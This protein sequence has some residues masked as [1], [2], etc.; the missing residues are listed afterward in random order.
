MSCYQH[1]ESFPLPFPKFL[2]RAPHT[3]LCFREEFLLLAGGV[4]ALRTPRVSSLTNPSPP[5]SP[6][7]TDCT[8]NLS[9]LGFG[10]WNSALCLY[11]ISALYYCYICRF[12]NQLGWERGFLTGFLGIKSYPTGGNVIS[13]T[14]DKVVKEDW[15]H[16]SRWNIWESLNCR[17]IR[18]NPSKDKG[19]RI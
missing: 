3:S 18:W 9:Q 14:I 10:E 13:P 19:L 16:E 12:C 15:R 5:G 1:F 17:S 8:A 4:G 7:L 6:A 2:V 11:F